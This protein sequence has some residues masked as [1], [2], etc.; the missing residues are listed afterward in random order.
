MKNS[1]ILSLWT[2]I[3][4]ADLRDLARGGGRHGKP[5]GMLHRIVSERLRRARLLRRRAPGIRLH[6]RARPARASSRCCSSTSASTCT[7]TAS[8][9]S[10][11]LGVGLCY[12]Y[13]QIPLMII[14]I[15]PA[16]EGL[17]TEWQEA[18]LNLGATQVR[19]SAP[20]GHPGA[21]PVLRRR[22]A[23]SVRQRLL[24]LCDRAGTRRQHARR[25]SRRR[26]TMRSTAT[27]SSAPTVP[28]SRWA[29]R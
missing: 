17:R 13:F 24:R 4:G 15:T 11:M 10:S 1:L 25:S 27:C 20:R 19:L 29:R 21:A 7:P 2:S 14:L 16:L 28:G 23:D 18:A 6:R 26:S 12:V 22:H 8:R 3:V 9:I 5:G